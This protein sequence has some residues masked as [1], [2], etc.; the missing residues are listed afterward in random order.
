MHPAYIE[1]QIQKNGIVFRMDRPAGQTDQHGQY[2]IPPDKTTPHTSLLY[3]YPVYPRSVPLSSKQVKRACMVPAEARAG[4][5]A[6]YFVFGEQCQATAMCDWRDGWQ[7]RRSRV[8]AVRP[9]R[10][11]FTW[12][13]SLTML[14]QLPVHPLKRDLNLGQPVIL[15][16][17]VPIPS[18]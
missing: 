8:V 16:L 6:T 18:M 10:K 17:P 9:H 4:A 2:K 11:A 13:V 15:A 5:L 3:L 12:R 14:V 1:M 7:T